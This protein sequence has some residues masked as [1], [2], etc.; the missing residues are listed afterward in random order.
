M[1]RKVG[2]FFFKNLLTPPISPY[3]MKRGE[4]QRFF[5]VLPQTLSSS[6]PLPPGGLGGLFESMTQILCWRE[7]RMEYE[8]EYRDLRRPGRLSNSQTGWKGNWTGIPRQ[9]TPEIASD[10]PLGVPVD[11]K[12]VEIRSDGDRSSPVNL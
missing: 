3:Q 11:G 9:G 7:G 5:A 10:E 8:E 1:T 2:G 6:V 4:L 12:P